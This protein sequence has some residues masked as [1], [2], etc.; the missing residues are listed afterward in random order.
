MERG[1]REDGSGELEHR[2]LQD[3][4]RESAKVLHGCECSILYGSTYI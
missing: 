2:V 3:V 4:F 1:R